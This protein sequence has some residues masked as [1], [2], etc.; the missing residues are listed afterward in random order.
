MFQGILSNFDSNAKV[1]GGIHCDVCGTVIKAPEPTE[2]T[3]PIVSAILAEDGSLT[4]S[5]GLSDNPVATNT[6]FVVVYDIDGKMLCVKNAE[7]L[8]QSDFSITIENM[9]GAHT[10]KV[11]RWLMPAQK[12]V[13]DE[14]NVR[15]E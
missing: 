11:L 7:K 9:S 15:V 12:P 2:P 5:G 14:V 4:V 3:G 13:Y 10:V 1:A 6:S 8:D